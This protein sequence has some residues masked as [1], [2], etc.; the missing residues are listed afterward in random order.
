MKI[1]TGSTLRLARRIYH[2][3]PLGFLRKAVN[4]LSMIIRNMEVGRMSRQTIQGI[5]FDL[6]L[7]ELIDYE[8]YREG[9]FER[10][11]HERLQELIVPGMTILDVGANIGAHAFFMSQKAGSKGHVYAFEPASYAFSKL[12][13]N[14]NLNPNL[15]ITLI[16]AG[17][18]SME[19]KKV[20]CTTFSSWRIDNSTKAGTI[21]HS[22]MKHAK[23]RKDIIDLIPL[24]LWIQHNKIG[25]IDLIKLDIDGNEI[26]FIQG[27]TQSLK[28]HKPIILFEWAESILNDRGYSGKDLMKL[29]KTFGYRFEFENG[30]KTDI[31]QATKVVEKEHLANKIYSINLI[32]FPNN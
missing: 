24:D 5:T 6:D 17:L 9:C 25:K 31:E 29:L 1:K 2:T 26:E 21:N 20:T 19:R 3:L 18:S 27:A 10:E 30:Q 15:N 13:S 12:K 16:N 14:A 7:G 32:A 22:A 8:I 4:P 28:K 23:G 11:T